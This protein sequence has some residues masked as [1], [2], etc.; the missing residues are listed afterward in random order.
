MDDTMKVEFP[1]GNRSV[2]M[3][4][5]SEGQ[6]LAIT[7]LRMPK[8]GDE[9]AVKHRFLQ[10]IIRFLEVLAGAGQWQEIEDGLLAEEIEPGDLLTLFS[11]V[12]Q[13]DWAGLAKAQARPSRRPEDESEPERRAPRVVSGG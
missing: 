8:E 7:I 3:S 2:I 11:D 9:P 13:F 5:P 12:T 10:R 6:L 4:R 1:L